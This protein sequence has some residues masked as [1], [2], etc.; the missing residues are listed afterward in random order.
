LQPNGNLPGT[1][2]LA[3]IESARYL[4]PWQKKIEQ[5]IAAGSILLTKTLFNPIRKILF[6][7]T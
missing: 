3:E 4:S 5:T 6:D 7:L 1:C 2:P